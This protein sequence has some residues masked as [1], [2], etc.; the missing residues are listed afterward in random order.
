MDYSDQAPSGPPK[1]KLKNDP[2]V[3]GLVFQAVALAVVFWLGWVLYSNTVTHLA[4][5]GIPSGFDFLQQTAGFGILFSLIPYNETMTYLRVFFVGL[6]NTLLV[7]VIGIVLATILGFLV[8]V[9]RLSS[10]WL[11]AKLSLAYVEIFRNVPLLL[12]ILFWYGFVL[13]T[14]PSVRDSISVGGLFFLSNRGLS[15]PFPHPEAGFQFVWLAF[16][17]AIVW[18]IGWTRYVNRRQD[19]TGQRLPVLWANVGAIIGLPLVVFLFL[20][21]PLHWIVP[22]LSAFNFTGG[23]V[24]LPEF[25]ALL[26]AL[27]MYTG[28]FIA[29]AVRSGITSVSHGQTEAARA[30]GLKPG[31]T[32]RLVVI[33]QA[34]RVIIPQVTSQYLNLTKNSSLAI[35]IG[36]P[37]LVAVFMGTT[38]LQTGRVLTIVFMTMAVYL[39][40]SL[41]ISLGMNLYNRAVSLEGGRS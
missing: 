10:N 26:V 8:G 40:I 36:Y 17:V 34:M 16:A 38:L 28:A 7:S 19:R 31:R 29:E 5:R 37:D 12:Q 9:A 24:I 15:M 39:V 41:L 23:L 27:T 21:A 20:G 6:L 1:K 13:R 25:T 22:E 3:R 11:L 14:L 18:S 2:R 33:P 32:L 30:L 4:E 35:A